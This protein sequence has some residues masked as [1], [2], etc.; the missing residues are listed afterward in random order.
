MRM[1]RKLSLQEAIRQE[2]E[3]V[4]AARRLCDQDSPQVEATAALLQRNHEVLRKSFELMK[5]AP[6]PPKSVAD[7]KIHHETSVKT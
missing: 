2:A 1:K 7:G 6:K 3:T 4:R 5:Y